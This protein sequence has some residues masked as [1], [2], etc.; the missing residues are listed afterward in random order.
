MGGRVATGD[1]AW[2]VEAL[3]LTSFLTP[4]TPW[5]PNTDWWTPVTERDSAS[6][7]VRRT[8]PLISEHG[9][10]DNSNVRLQVAPRRVDFVVQQDAPTDEPQSAAFDAPLRLFQRIGERWL[11]ISP[12][13]TRLAVG[14]ELLSGIHERKEGYRRLLRYLP[15]VRMDVDASTDLAYQINRPRPTTT[16]VSGLMINRLS[17]WS[18]SIVQRVLVAAG[19]VPEEAISGGE[20]L[21][22][23]RV[24]LDV[25][26]GAEFRSSLPQDKLLPLFNELTSLALEIAERGDIA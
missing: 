5:D 18:V 17:N 3:R 2:Q 15:Y 23:C 21:N 7:T 9:H 11:R 19:S 20:S 13:T 10:I 14:A 6:R 4:E 12:A 24:V 16:G 26:T 25:N 1:I 8:P 22:V